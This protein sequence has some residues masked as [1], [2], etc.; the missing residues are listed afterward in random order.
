MESL[1]NNDFI[2]HLFDC[3]SFCYADYKHFVFFG[4]SKGKVNFYET[5]TKFAL[6]F[7]VLLFFLY[8]RGSVLV[9]LSENIIPF[10][11]REEVMVWISITFMVMGF[12]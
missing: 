9:D 6:I 8:L 10:S 3:S 5:P 7:T 2:E 1:R 11:R 4:F 12:Y